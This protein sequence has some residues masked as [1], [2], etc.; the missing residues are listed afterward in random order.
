M[1]PE[2]LHSP[3]ALLSAL[4]CE[5]QQALSDINQPTKKRVKR[6]LPSPQIRFAIAHPP[7]SDLPLAASRPPARHSPS[8]FWTFSS[9]L[10]MRPALLLLLVACLFTAGLAG[11]NGG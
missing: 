2:C 11:R 10:I 7:L 6:I 1:L 5:N 3:S 8:I 4:P 9:P